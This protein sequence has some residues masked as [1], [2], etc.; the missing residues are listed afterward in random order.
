MPYEVSQ[1][2]EFDNLILL[3]LNHHNEVHKRSDLTRDKYPPEILKG[4]REKRY[5]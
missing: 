3:C 1:N 2:N 4:L 5:K